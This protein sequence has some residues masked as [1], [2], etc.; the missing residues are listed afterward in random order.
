M[1][2]NNTLLM[3]VALAA[4]TA[5]LGACSESS[6][7]D[8]A[9]DQAP[10]SSST[11]ADDRTDETSASAEE[12]DDAEEADLPDG[13][14]TL[15]VPGPGEDHPTL[16]AGR[17]RVPLS[18]TLAFD[19]DVPD[20]T[21]AHD[22]GLFL[23]TGSVVLKTEIAGEQYGVPSEAC[24]E[25]F[26]EPVG[27]E[28]NDIVEAIRQETIYRVTR[29]QPVEL[30][31]AE[32]TYLEIRI[33]RSYD[34]TKCEGRDVLTPGNPGTAVSWK[35]GYTGRYWILD[36]DGQRVVASQNC[37]CPS[38]ELSDALKIAQSITFTPTP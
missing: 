16:R 29:P 15:P 6:A 7:D 14:V 36:I 2:R 22:D 32:G 9:A 19:V 33:P 25:H 10:S 34:A 28:V 4:V 13:V 24:T 11:R 3:S 30:G 17:Y 38:Q 1:R 8:D 18:D 26:I 12:T 21:N 23:A 37:A 27:P 20:E 35:P 5:L 31:G